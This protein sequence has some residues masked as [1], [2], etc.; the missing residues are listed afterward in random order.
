MADVSRSRVD[1]VLAVVGLCTC[2]AMSFFGG[3]YVAAQ[4][5][6]GAQLRQFLR[7]Q[8]GGIQK[9]MKPSHDGGIPGSWLPDGQEN[10]ELAKAIAATLRD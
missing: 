9:L 10:E 4:G 6:N 2:V 3:R 7:Q 8:V 5:V 1:R